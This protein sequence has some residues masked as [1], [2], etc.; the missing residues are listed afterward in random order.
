LHLFT[1][2]SL[3]STGSFFN[4][5]FRNEWLMSRACTVLSMTLFHA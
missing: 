3:S 5:L 4:I 2:F 1:D